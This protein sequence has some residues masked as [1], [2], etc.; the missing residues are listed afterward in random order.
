MQGRLCDFAL[1]GGSGE[2][3][4]LA[5][6]RGQG[7]GPSCAIS[8][9]DQGRHDLFRAASKVEGQEMAVLKI[10]QRAVVAT[11]LLNAAVLIALVSRL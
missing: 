6:F 11:V 7:G 3:Q 4:V 9:T 8:H 2:S 1:N 10:N 5:D